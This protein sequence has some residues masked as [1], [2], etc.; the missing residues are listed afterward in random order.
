[1]LK[2]HDPVTVPRGQCEVVED[3]QHKRSSAG[4]PAKRVHCFK[5][6]RGI[7][8]CE[9]FVDE[10]NAR[11]AGKRPSEED[12]RPLATGELRHGAALEPKHIRGPHCF[13]NR[14]GIFPRCPPRPPPVGMATKANNVLDRQGPRHLPVLG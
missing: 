4:E 14:N 13:L 3:E 6:V 7:Q 8:A 5:L 1:M 11:T 9:R 10:E 12:P 2:Q